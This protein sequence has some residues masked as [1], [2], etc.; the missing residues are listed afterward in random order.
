MCPTLDE[1]GYEVRYALDFSGLTKSA[2][3]AIR[4]LTMSHG[5]IPHGSGSLDQC[6]AI[7]LE[8]DID[9]SWLRSFLQKEDLPKKSCRIVVEILTETDDRI[10]DLPDF[11]VDLVK[12][13]ACV[14][15]EFSVTHP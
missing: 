10:I 12:A 9:Y 4:S 1:E 2:R 14:G 6:S 7:T 3:E 11:V 5:A 15:L 13:A 8:E